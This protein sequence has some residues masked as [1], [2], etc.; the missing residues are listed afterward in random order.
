MMMRNYKCLGTA[1]IDAT[2]EVK[3]NVKLGYLLQNEDGTI[4]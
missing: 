4:K 3:L 2:D 1:D